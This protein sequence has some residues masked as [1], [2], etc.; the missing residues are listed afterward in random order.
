MHPVQSREIEIAS[1]DDIVASRSHR[2]LVE[3]RDFVPIAVVDAGENR[4][5]G[6]QIE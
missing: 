2:D 6:A 5:A 1:V 3:R 4:N